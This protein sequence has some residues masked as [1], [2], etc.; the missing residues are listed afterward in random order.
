MASGW[1]YGEVEN[2]SKKTSPYL[3]PYVEL[4]ETIKDQDRD[5]V[6]SIPKLLDRIGMAIYQKDH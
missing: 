3:V 5:V 2:T 1:T 6:R 4:S